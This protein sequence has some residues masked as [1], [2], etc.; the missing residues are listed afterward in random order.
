MQCHEVAFYYLMKSRGTKEIKSNSY[1][2]TSMGT[3]K[4]N[5]YWLPISDLKDYK[6]FP[7]FFA[8]ELLNISLTVKH[9]ITDERK[10]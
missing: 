6:V 2:T 9:I 8:E 10:C 4:E 5:M 7:S 1:T 3:Y